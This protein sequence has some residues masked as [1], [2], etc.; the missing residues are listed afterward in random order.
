MVRIASAARASPDSESP[1]AA[2]AMPRPMLAIGRGL[3]ITPVEA[4]SISAG[5][6]PTASAARARHLGRVAPAA[7]AHRDVRAAAV[8]DHAARE[9]AA[10]P[11]P[12]QLDGR[13]DHAWNG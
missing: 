12:A 11:A 13:A 9:A 1:A 4:T 3:P 5:A 8:H 6:A 2:A 10:H 7:L